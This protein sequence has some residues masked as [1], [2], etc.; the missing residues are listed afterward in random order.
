LAF[1][2]HECQ[3]CTRRR[4]NVRKRSTSRLLGLTASSR[5]HCSQRAYSGLLETSRF[6]GNGSGTAPLHPEQWWGH[7]ATQPV[8]FVCC[9]SFI[10]AASAV[11]DVK[12]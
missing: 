7:H 6:A 12:G 2:M 9:V 1:Q 8:G 4:G 3:F 5:F 11:F 10:V